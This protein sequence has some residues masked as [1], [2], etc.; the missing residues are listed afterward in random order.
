ME[1]RP[2]A[3]GQQFN[4][5]ISCQIEIIVEWAYGAKN[6]NQGIRVGYRNNANN[7]DAIEGAGKVIVNNGLERPKQP[8]SQQK[9]NDCGKQQ[10]LGEGINIDVD[11]NQNNQDSFEYEGWRA[12]P[13][14]NSGATAA[15]K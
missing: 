14:G 12:Q 9:E 7:T 15:I 2:G 6:S 11:I 5:K 8:Y 4:I 10:D 1:S 3:G 13:L